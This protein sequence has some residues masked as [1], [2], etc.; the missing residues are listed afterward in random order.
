MIEEGDRLLLGLSGGKDSLALLHILLAF[1]KR[2]P[3]KYTFTFLNLFSP[4]TIII[5]IIIIIIFW[6]NDCLFQIYHFL[7]YRRSP[8]RFLRP[9]SADTLRTKPG[10]NLPFLIGAYRGPREVEVTGRFPLRLLLS[11]Q[12]RLALFLL[13]V[14]NTIIYHESLE[15]LN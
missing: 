11:L 15:L 3:V 4:T 2:A 5:I 14:R 13:S 8:N 12:E 10:G 6:K 7:C 9:Q 1:Q